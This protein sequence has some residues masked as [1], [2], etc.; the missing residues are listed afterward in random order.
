MAEERTTK[1]ELFSLK[2]GRLRGDVIV[3][4]MMRDQD[5]DGKDF[6]VWKGAGAHLKRTRMST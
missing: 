2:Q 4:Q 5:K 3:Y 6:T 1:R